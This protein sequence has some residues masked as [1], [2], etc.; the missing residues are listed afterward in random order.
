MLFILVMDVLVYMFSKVENDGLL[1]QLS[2][3]KKLHSLH[4]C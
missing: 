2:S 4:V 1:Q 3:S